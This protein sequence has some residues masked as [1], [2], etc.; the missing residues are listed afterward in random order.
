MA[1][2]YF[3]NYQTTV[4]PGGYTAASGVL[5]V[6]STSGITLNSGD[7][8]RLSLYTGSPELVVILIVTAVNSST[9]FAV[10]AETADTNAS[11]GDLVLNTLTVGGMNQIRTD[12]S[13]FGPRANL[14]VPAS[15]FLVEGQRYQCTDSPYE[16]I[17]NGTSWDAYVFGFQVVEPIL[18]N[19]TQVNVNSGVNVTLDTSHGG[20]NFK[21]ISQG[22][23]EN[24][25]Y[26]A[27]A[28]PGSGA[29]F[30]DVAFLAFGP[31]GNGGFG[32]GLSAGT[33]STTSKFAL[34]GWPWQSNSFNNWQEKEYN[35]CTSHN[36]DNGDVQVSL[37][38]P[39]IWL[40]VQD[41]RVTNRTW[42]ISQNGQDWMQMFQQA[43][44]TNFTPAFGIAC[45][46]PFNL[47]MQAHL[48]HFSIHT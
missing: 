45:A 30:V 41:D 40:R 29:Y 39:M 26:L 1:E 2:R 33:S 12:I 31:Q 11:A 46:V 21:I 32:V 27:Q 47:N 4:G 44:T 8:T 23:A 22:S 35:S 16:F 6:L 38:A 7:T 17:F 3:N 48:L 36:T 42:F 25:A 34:A 9:Q 43:R 10:T 19:F 14:P 5:N 24:C 20:I 15:S 18:A 37:T 28:V 13:M